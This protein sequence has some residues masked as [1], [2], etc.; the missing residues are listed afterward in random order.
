MNEPEKIGGAIK[1]ALLALKEEAYFDRIWNVL[2]TRGSLIKE[3]AVMAWWEAS[4]KSNPYPY[5][6]KTIGWEVDITLGS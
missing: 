3:R 5:R 4:K 6:R 2:Q 1:R